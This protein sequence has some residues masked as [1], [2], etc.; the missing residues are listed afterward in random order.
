MDFTFLAGRFT[1]N[2]TSVA[3]VNNTE[4]VIDVTVPAGK[5][6]FLM[7]VRMVNADDVA[8]TIIAIIYKE[9]AKTNILLPLFTKSGLGAAGVIVYPSSMPTS[10]GAYMAGACAPPG[11]ILEAGHTISFTWATGGA[12]TG[13]T[14]AD[15]LCVAVLEVDAP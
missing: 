15:G 13:A 6:W 8:R 14:D 12:S 7:F 1:D 4:K 5:R 11:I 9:A 2:L 10:A 3:L